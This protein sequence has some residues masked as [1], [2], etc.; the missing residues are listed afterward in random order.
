MRH[1]HGIEG[2]ITEEL[3]RLISERLTGVEEKVTTHILDRDEYT[4]SIGQIEALR[5]CKEE[6]RALEEKLL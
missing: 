4:V 2:T 3:T 6:V 5:W 1:K